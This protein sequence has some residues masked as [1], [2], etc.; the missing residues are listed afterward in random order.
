M[1]DG[2]GSRWLAGTLLGLPLATAL[3][4]LAVLWLPGGWWGG[5]M[6]LVLAF[7]PVWVGIICGSLFF[8]SSRAAWLWLAGANLAGFGALWAAGLAGILPAAPGF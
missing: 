8:R 3:C 2:I 4:T 5:V 6:A 7:F 1:N